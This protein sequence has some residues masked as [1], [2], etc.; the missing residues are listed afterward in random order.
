MPPSFRAALALL[1][2]AAP[3]L[4]SRAFTFTLPADA[5]TNDRALL[6]TAQ[7]LLNRAT[8]T[9]WLYEPVF[10]TY[11]NA[12]YYFAQD[13]LPRVKGFAFTPLQGDFCALAAGAGGG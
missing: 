8:P 13:Y 5:P 7:G 6:L 12:T 11:P 9:L 4:A 1:L 2:A 3:A 10:W